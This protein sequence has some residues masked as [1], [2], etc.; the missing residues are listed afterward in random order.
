MYNESRSTFL[1]PLTF[2]DARWWYSHAGIDGEVW[3]KLTRPTEMETLFVL[4]P[5]LILLA[6]AESTRAVSFVVAD[7]KAGDLV[8]DRGRGKMGDWGRHSALAPVVNMDIRT[9]WR[10]VKYLVRF[11]I[12][13][14]LL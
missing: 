9:T 1:V 12:L 13:G 6:N 10:R 2:P 8:R 4:K 14:F 11:V 3:S 5:A 7:W